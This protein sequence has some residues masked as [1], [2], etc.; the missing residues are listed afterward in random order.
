MKYLKRPLLF[1]A[2]FGLVPV[3]TFHFEQRWIDWGK[4]LSAILGSSGTRDN[5]REIK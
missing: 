3:S 1:P 4:R 5:A 2:T